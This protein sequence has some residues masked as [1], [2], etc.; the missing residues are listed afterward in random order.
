MPGDRERFD[1]GVVAR[2]ARP[3]R[4]RAPRRRRTCRP[5]RRRRAFDPTD[6]VDAL[7]ALGL[8]RRGDGRRPRCR[9]RRLRD[10]RRRRRRPGRSRSTCPR[11][12][13]TRSA[14][15]RRRARRSTTSSVV[16]GRA[17]SATC[18]TARHAGFVFSRNVLHQVPDFWKAIDAGDRIHDAARPGGVLRLSDLVYDFE[19]GDAAA[20]I[21][22]VGSPVR[23]TTRPVAGRPTSWPNTSAPSTARSP[24]CSSRCSTT[25]ASR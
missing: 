16:H 6:D 5:T 4:T 22:G 8:D 15:A 9:H 11:R 17:C 25:P 7:V 24:G 19:P 20:A 23:S 10:R 13:S 3:R 18:T 21:D 14:P 1:A 12:W 2:R